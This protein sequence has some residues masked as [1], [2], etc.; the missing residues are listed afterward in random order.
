M[1]REVK[2]LGH[3]VSAEGV[4]P[5]PKK[6]QAVMQLSVPCN[7]REVRS[8]LGLAGYYCH[9]IDAFAIVAAPLYAL[10]KEGTPFKW[11]DQQQRAFDTLKQRLCSAPVLRISKKRTEVHS[12]L[13]C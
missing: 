8:F 13:R 5:D 3:V 4:K 10:T 12:R 11:G 6:I 7:V 1:S 9:F 2:Y